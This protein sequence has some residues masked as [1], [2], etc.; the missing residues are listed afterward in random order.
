MAVKSTKGRINISLDKEL[1]LYLRTRA[2]KNKRTISNEVA[3]ILEEFKNKN[4][5]S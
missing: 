3:Y 1:I 5:E 4:K 2:D